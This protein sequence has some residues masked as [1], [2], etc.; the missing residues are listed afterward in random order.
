VRLVSCDMRRLMVVYP[1]RYPVLIAVDDFQALFC[2]SK[3]RNPQYD[4][5][6]A[7]HLAIPRVILEYAS[8]KRTLVSEI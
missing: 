5:I 4:L 3:Y 2:M 1:Q 8:G 7:H 6:S